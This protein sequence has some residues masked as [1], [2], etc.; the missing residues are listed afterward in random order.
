MSN[1]ISITDLRQW[2]TKII[3]T[4][5]DT[6]DQIVFVNNKPK[7]VLIDYDEY[8]EMLDR[9]VELVEFA[10]DDLSDADKKLVEQV[11]QLP[12]SSFVNI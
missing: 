6:G 3:N 2:A 9:P 8:Q 12:E 5:P 7:A 4:L 10:Y 11:K 1:F